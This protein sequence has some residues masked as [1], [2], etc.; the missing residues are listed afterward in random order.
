MKGNTI[1]IVNFDSSYDGGVIP[2]VNYSDALVC[3]LSKMNDFENEVDCDEERLSKK[4][5]QQEMVSDNNSVSHTPFRAR[6]DADN[7]E[8][9]YIYVEIAKETIQ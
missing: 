1:Y 9:D 5:L 2:F 4:I 6:I 7:S 8:E 3:A